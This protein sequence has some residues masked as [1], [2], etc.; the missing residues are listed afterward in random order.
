[1][2]AQMTLATRLAFNGIDDGTRA[3]LR[4]YKDFIMQELPA[5]LDRFY[6]HVGRFEDARAFFRSR[7]HMDAAKSAQIRHW[8]T[9][10]DGRFDA[11]YEA[12]I[13]RIGEA[14]HRIGLDTSWYI[15]G[16]NGLLS[17][18][19]SVIG[20][21]LEAPRKSRFGGGSVQEDVRT[22]LQVAIT[23]IALLDM[24]YAIS[25]YIEAGRRE[26]GT[27]ASSVV[28]LATNVA[29][30]THHLE[31][32]AAQLSGTAKAATERTTSVASAA[33]EAS[34]NVRAVASAAE[35]LAGSVQEIGRQVAASTD[36]ANKAVR[37]V[38][39]TSE[40]V[41]DLAE[42]AAQIG[43]VVELINNIA[44]QTNLLALNATIEA[45]RA[46]EAGKGFAVVAQE[47]KSLAS[48][49][50]KA[51]EGIGAQV[52]HIQAATTDAVQSI[53]LI[54]ALISDMSAATTTIA[55]AVEEQGAATA[56][57]ARN[58]QE[59][60]QGTSEVAANTTGLGDAASST[61]TVAEKVATSTKEIAADAVKLQKLAAGF[62]GNATAA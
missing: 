9:L 27:L 14:H 16:Y 37:T 4:Q 31:G 6:A 44:R 48:Q 2:T 24:D 20:D 39:E 1:M 56:N 30:T 51:T 43:T 57:I 8:S 53:N 10:M 25:V 23:R 52:S 45:A 22:A 49:T 28:K 34:V 15:G 54:T 62:L 42:A 18:L 17:G 60:A 21:K 55:S 13:K 29:D 41:R 46:G 58:V 40:K 5:V 38:T 12:S 11:T 7:E 33:E 26:L 35:E 59:A 19:L 61:R 32:A 36:M 50:G 47:V 3:L